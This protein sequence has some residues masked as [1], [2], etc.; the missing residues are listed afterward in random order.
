MG[1]GNGLDL[2]VGCL[3]AFQVTCGPDPERVHQG[4][5]DNE[6]SGWGGRN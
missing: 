3:R 2:G 1:N 5:F 6:S 4:E